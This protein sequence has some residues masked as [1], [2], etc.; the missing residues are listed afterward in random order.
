MRGATTVCRALVLETGWFAT[1]PSATWYTM[2][3][4]ML[5]RLLSA[6]S[7]D[8]FLHVQPEKVC[9]LP[10]L[11]AVPLTFGN[12]EGPAAELKLG[13]SLFVRV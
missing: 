12:Q 4:E 11:L 7:Q 3:P 9:Q 5:D 2:I 1:M 13:T 8:C 10:L 6:K